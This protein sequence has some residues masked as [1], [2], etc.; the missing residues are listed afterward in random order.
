MKD[1][2]EFDYLTIEARG[3][4][5]FV[6]YGHS[7]YGEES[8]LEGQP[9]KRFITSFDT[10]EEAR[11]VYPEAELSHPLLQKKAALPEEPPSW[12]DPTAA[13]ERWLEEN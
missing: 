1:T 3:D 6:V 10:E 5:G 7:T 13:G 2:G 11:A 8:I 12:F 9:K 4:L